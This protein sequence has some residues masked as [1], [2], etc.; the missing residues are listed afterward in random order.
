MNVSHSRL[1]FV[2]LGLSLFT[3]APTCGGGGGG[4]DEGG[5]ATSTDAALP[6]TTSSDAG[7]DM[8]TDDPDASVTLGDRRQLNV[9]VKVPTQYRFEDGEFSPVAGQDAS[10]QVSDLRR[11]VPDVSRAD[12]WAPTDTKWVIA[13]EDKPEWLDKAVRDERIEKGHRYFKVPGYLMISVSET[14]GDNLEDYREDLPQ[15]IDVDFVGL[16]ASNVLQQPRVTLPNKGE[17][18][19]PG[20]HKFYVVVEREP[21]D[22]RSQGL[23]AIGRIRMQMEFAEDS[24]FWDAEVAN[25]YAAGSEQFATR[26]KKGE[27]IWTTADGYGMPFNPSET[28]DRQISK[29]V[30]DVQTFTTAASLVL[31]GGSAA[32]AALVSGR[33]AIGVFVAWLESFDTLVAEAGGRVS[34]EFGET[35]PGKGST[36]P[37]NAALSG[38]DSA[39]VPRNS[40]EADEGRKLVYSGPHLM[41]QPRAYK[42]FE[43]TGPPN[44]D[45]EGT[46][47]SLTSPSNGATA[48][49]PVEIGLEVQ[50]KDPSSSCVVGFGDGN[51]MSVDCGGDGVTFGTVEHKWPEPGTYTLSIQ[52]RDRTG[53]TTTTRQLKV[54]PHPDVVLEPKDRVVTMDK[55]TY[56]PTDLVVERLH[57][58]KGSVSLKQVRAFRLDE[59]AEDGER[60][61][62]AVSAEFDTN[63]LDANEQQTSIEVRVDRGA[64][65]GQY[66][67]VLQA[68][69]DDK[70]VDEAYIGVSVRAPGERLPVAGLAQDARFGH[71][72]ALDR[73]GRRAVVGAPNGGPDSLDGSLW[74]Y[75]RKEGQ[76]RLERRFDSEPK[77]GAPSKYASVVSLGRDVAMSDDGTVAASGSDMGGAVL[78]RHGS[79]EWS[80]SRVIQAASFVNHVRVALDGDG[81]VLAHSYGEPPTELSVQRPGGAELAS[82]VTYSYQF[83]LD[84]S[85]SLVA[86]SRGETRRSEGYVHL[87]SVGGGR[88]R[89]RP[90]EL[91]ESKGQITNGFPGSVVLDGEGDELLASAPSRQSLFVVARESSG[92]STQAE[93][94]IQKNSF[95]LH[96]PIAFSDDGGTAAAIADPPSDSDQ[97]HVVFFAQQ[98]SGWMQARLVPVASVQRITSLALDGDGD[99]ALVGS[100]GH[101][102]A[103]AV[104]EVSGSQ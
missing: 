86:T 94:N 35:A 5:G 102:R 62:D 82:D 59:D 33:A 84:R 20:V 16:G 73:S 79:S 38:I 47:A 6:D 89:V 74:I 13:P 56:V 63:T 65:P 27:M 50:S 45:P 18:L 23:S 34:R 91:K 52:V 54:S 36:T 29:G 10:L 11:I 92:W 51:E 71:S 66:G 43:P 75:R 95:G 93:L 67:L 49:E 68:E 42:N 87:K 39:F 15:S 19:G 41:F 99:Y 60:E 70:V 85:G 83:D 37:I 88:S 31:I 17:G 21:S 100:A 104:F 96:G 2:L 26:P 98:A 101:G 44:R 25:H 90:D 58:F 64:D 61:T 3:A 103:G 48:G 81:D 4:S 69:G 80:A 7:S 40:R 28:L 8:G 22:A 57:G 77:P 30:Q 76:W 72:V 78:Y 97:D 1:A 9:S 12:N 32:Q 53:L 55:G 14:I 24:L 46:Q